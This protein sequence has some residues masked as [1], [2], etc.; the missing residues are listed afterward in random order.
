VPPT[1][2]DC[3]RTLFPSPEEAIEEVRAELHELVAG[4][5]LES[6]HIS[7]AIEQLVESGVELPLVMATVLDFAPVEWLG[8]QK[9]EATNVSDFE[10]LAAM[11][12]LDP[13]TGR[14]LGAPPALR[15]RVARVD[16]PPSS[17]FGQRPTGPAA[18]GSE[19]MR[20]RPL[21]GWSRNR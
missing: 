9:P 18:L 14:Q 8:Q 21:A 13:N 7:W 2:Q 15:V 12:G 16:A 17:R 6:L 5:T 11:L 1:D 19:G 4:S 3:F 10:G 20:Q